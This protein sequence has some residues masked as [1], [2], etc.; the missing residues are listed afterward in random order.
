MVVSEK[1]MSESAL[2]YNAFTLRRELLQQILDET[3]DLDTE[4][5]YPATVKTS[6]YQTM[7]NRDGIGTRVTKLMPEESWNVAPEIVENEESEETPFEEAWK[8]LNE[9]HHL[10]HYLLRLDVLS[11]I[12]RYGLLLI[13]INDGKKL[14][15]PVEGI[16]LKTGK[17][18]LNLKHEL[19]YLRPLSETVVVV[20]TKETDVTSLRYGRPVTYG[21]VTENLDGETSSSELTVHWTRVIHVAEN[22]T[23]SE[24]FGTPRMQIVYNYL[25]DI[26]KLLGGSAEM[27]W[28]GG[29]PGIAFEVN[30]ARTTALTT[31][32]KTDLRAEFENY[33]NHLQRYLALTGVT[34]KSLELQVADPQAHFE[35]QL[36]AI[37]MALGIPYRLLLGAE[38]AE[39]ASSQDVKV[40]N[41]RVKNRQETHCSS[42]ILRP[43][44]D[45]LITF[46]VLP[47]PESYTIKWASLDALDPKDQA[48][49]CKD[50]TEAIAKYVSAGADSLIP[51]RQFLTAVMGFTNEEAEMFLEEAAAW[52]D[53]GVNED[54]LE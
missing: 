27:L 44:I 15:E 26:K 46:G 32:E 48:K 18:S 28:R 5:G 17:S 30:P 49:V 39:L 8:E 13:G 34:A 4:C 47:P 23:T 33:S 25:L 3:R 2:L 29:F 43:F 40:W 21:F 38:K 50:R 42:E 53:D 52:S 7:F 54:D 14:N 6:D 1:K 45:R 37:G 41:R 22:K 31:E 20:K 24:I 36:K 11:G 10:F 16:D 35:I 12:G 9:E 51:P 19:T